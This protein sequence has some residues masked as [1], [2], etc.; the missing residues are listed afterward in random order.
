MISP[1]LQ[2]TAIADY[3]ASRGYEIVETITDLDLSGRLWKR[4]RVEAAV[5]LIE[6]GGADV[7]VVWK[8]SRVARNRLDWAIA[9]DR[10]EAA[11]GRLESATEPVDATTS[12]GRLARGMLAEFAA[13]ESDRIGDVWREV[14][15]RRTKRGLPANG[16]ARFGYRNIDGVH[17]P[18]PDTGPV[19]AELY[20]RYVAGESMASLVVW[21][22]GEGIRTVAGYS[23]RG[24]GP[25][26]PTSLRVMLDNGFAA[27]Y[28]TVRGERQAGAHAPLIDAQTWEAY[29][30]ARIR[31][32]RLRR[33]ESSQYLLSSMVWCSCGSKMGYGYSK[34]SKKAILRCLKSTQPGAARHPKAY[35][36]ASLV[37]D[38]VREWVEGEASRGQPSAD[39]ALA[40][41]AR[42]TRRRFD[43]DALGREV[44][45]LD[46]AISRL[47]VDRARRLVPESAYQLGLAELTVQHRLAKERHTVA[48]ADAAAP[49][50]TAIVAD[51]AAHWDEYGLEYLRDSLRQVIER[52][53]VTGGPPLT[54][55][56]VTK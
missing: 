41:A 17:E 19:L 3:C 6:S 48:L 52:V 5:Q 31:R 49:L 15:A 23:A 45:E 14:H 1:E 22:N 56:V 42:A 50:N 16:K 20:R 44:L 53:T 32:R 12:T 40:D 7:L 36:T 24:G 10:V 28:I 25:W 18:D 4:R 27:G 35:V 9:V 39:Q 43:A 11:H 13:F 47:T 34:T 54:I 29:Q 46:K 51:L 8:W 30:A 38:L 2:A 37:E 55:D 33:A 26:S 21:L